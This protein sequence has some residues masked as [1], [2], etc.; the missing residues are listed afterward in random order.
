MQFSPAVDSNHILN[1]V[2]GHEEIE[3]LEL[4]KN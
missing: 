3:L 1:N 4:M 2:A